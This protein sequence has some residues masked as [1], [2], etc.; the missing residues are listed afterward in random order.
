MRIPSP[1]SLYLITF[2]GF[3]PAKNIF[4][5]TCH[6][7]VDTRSSIGRRRSFKKGEGLRSFS[8]LHGLFKDLIVLPCGEHALSYLGIINLLIFLIFFLVIYF[9]MSYISYHKPNVSYKQDWISSLWAG[10]C[11]GSHGI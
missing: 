11:S 1:F 3:V 2:Q 10:Q 9:V 6:D 7:M 4:D 5:G 8:I